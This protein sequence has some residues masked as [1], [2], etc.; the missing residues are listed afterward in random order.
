MVQNNFFFSSK[1]NRI[2]IEVMSTEEWKEK[3]K[4]IT[5]MEKR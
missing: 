5:K 1:R 4:K 3:V 2:N